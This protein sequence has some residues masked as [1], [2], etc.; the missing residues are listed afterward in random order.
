MHVEN[1]LHTC[2]YVA[3]RLLKCI[4]DRALQ[5]STVVDVFVTSHQND[6]DETI[7]KSI[8]DIHYRL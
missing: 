3:I 7:T 1:V 6:D 2:I 8:N 5:K 4:Q